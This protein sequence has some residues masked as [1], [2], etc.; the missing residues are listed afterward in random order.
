MIIRPGEPFQP[1]QVYLLTI[2]RGVRDYRRNVMSAPVQLVYS[3]G[4]DIPVGRIAG[5]VLGVDPEQS[6]EVG[7]FGRMDTTRAWMLT[8]RVALSADASFTFPNLSDGSYRLA[9]VEGGLGSFPASIHIQPYAIPPMDS[10]VIQDG[11]TAAVELYLSPPLA[12][13]QIQ[14]AEWINPSYA[15][16]SFNVPFDEG[17]RPPSL[18][19]TG[20]PLELGLVVEQ[21]GADTILIALGEIRNRLGNPY[22]LQ[23]FVT[24]VPEMVDT[25]P[26]TVV[27]R[28]Q[29]VVLEPVESDPFVEPSLSMR[30]RIAFSEPVRIPGGLMA[31][32]TGR[33][34]VEAPLVADSPLALVFE[35]VVPERIEGVRIPANLITDVAG[36]AM[37]D[38]ILVLETVIE[39][40]SVGGR[41]RGSLSGITGLVVVEAWEVESDERVVFTVTDSSAWVIDPVPPGF[42]VL[43]AHE[44]LGPRFLPYF[45]GSWQP[46]HRSA[47]FTFFPEVIEVR[48]RWEVDGIDINFGRD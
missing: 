25:L 21:P 40:P 39:Q 32:L 47:R 11:D 44:Q 9:A 31:T 38:S 2:E 41:L 14:F 26:P 34:T 1:G 46:Y 33:D 5:Q 24:A 28:Q 13:P 30:G 45:S 42:Y 18:V 8:R 16:V 19:P 6:V 27:N 20:D 4:V 7:L 3:T 17:F 37:E 12:Q 48:P 29:R 43:F 35:T 23:P 10:L 15:L 36:N 22:L